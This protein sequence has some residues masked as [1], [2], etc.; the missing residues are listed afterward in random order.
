[1]LGSLGAFQAKHPDLPITAANALA[2]LASSAKAI[3]DA[4]Q[5]LKAYL[6]NADNTELSYLQAGTHYHDNLKAMKSSVAAMTTAMKD[7]PPA[8]T[9][10]G[11]AHNGKHVGT[12]AACKAAAATSK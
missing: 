11:G 6:K 5:D 7:C 4:A 1:V 10:C 2:V 9:D 12:H 8:K 3:Y